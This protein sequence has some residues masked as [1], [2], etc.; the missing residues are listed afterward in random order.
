MDLKVFV[1]GSENEPSVEGAIKLLE[2]KERDP[3]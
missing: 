1:Y 3:R 2:K